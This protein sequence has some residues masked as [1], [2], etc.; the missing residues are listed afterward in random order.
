MCVVQSGSYFLLEV[1]RAAYRGLLP[2]EF[3]EGLSDIH[4]SAH[5]AEVL[6]SEDR[7]G[8]TFIAEA[9][10][11]GIVGFADCGPERAAAEAKNGEVTAIYIL[12]AWQRK[13]VGTNLMETCAGH[14]A[15]GGAET[16][17]VWVLEANRPAG[18]FYEALGGVP[19]ETREIT[20]AGEELSE[21]CY[22]WADI[23]AL[24]GL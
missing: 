16:L 11:D 22:R 7:V 17:A 3:L 12:P 4:H 10:A 21:Q 23:S 24:A 8:A 19:S 2:E 13:G 14:L 6:D 20:F 18:E 9:E 5:W 15:V 1:W